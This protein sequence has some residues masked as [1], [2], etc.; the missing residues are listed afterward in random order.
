MKI[1]IDIS[2]KWIIMFDK[3]LSMKHTYAIK[4]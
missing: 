3:A 1:I 2:K 4:Y